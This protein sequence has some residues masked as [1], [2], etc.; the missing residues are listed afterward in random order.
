[1]RKLFVKIEVRGKMQIGGMKVRY[2]DYRWGQNKRNY[3]EIYQ[4]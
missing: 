4:N 2:N 3:R 1:M